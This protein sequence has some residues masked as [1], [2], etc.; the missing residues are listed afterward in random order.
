MYLETEYMMRDYI[1]KRM[2][3][4]SWFTLGSL[5]TDDGDAKDDAFQKKKGLLL[6]SW[7]S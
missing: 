6:Y 4:P 2:Y 7:I 3:S 5:S 1:W